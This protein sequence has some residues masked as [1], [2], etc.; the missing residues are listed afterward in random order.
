MK[1]D[2]EQIREYR[3]SLRDEVANLEVKLAVV[4]KFLEIAQEDFRMDLDR[5]IKPYVDSSR[6]LLTDVKLSL[7]KAGFE[8]HT[9]EHERRYITPSVALRI[10]KEEGILTYS[11]SLYSVKSILEELRDKGFDLK[12]HSL[13]CALS[14]SSDFEYDYY[15]G[16]YL[17][18]YQDSTYE[19]KYNDSV[20]RRNRNVVT[21]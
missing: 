19:E 11:R 8:H 20:M 16:W 13:K 5:K 10:I 3:Q 6:Y 2:L 15:K 18:D 7:L 21:R 1:K 17:K 9:I 12:L 14:Q 4:D